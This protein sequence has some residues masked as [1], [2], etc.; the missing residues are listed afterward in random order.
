V[1]K[2]PQRNIYFVGHSLGGL[3]I[4]S[5]LKKYMP[6]HQG[7]VVL[8]GSPV[9]GSEL[10]QSIANRDYGKYLLGATHVLWKKSLFKKWDGKAEVGAIAGISSPSIASTLFHQLKKPSDGVVTVEET[11]LPGFKAHITVPA[12]HT[13]GLLLSSQVM[14]QTE[15]F[16]KTGQFL[17]I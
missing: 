4:L 6:K 7:R 14:K 1:Q 16:L 13:I 10:G 17:T 15:A 2:I 9:R 3:V 12:G 11:K 8:L 5:M